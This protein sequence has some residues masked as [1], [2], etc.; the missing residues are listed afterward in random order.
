MG[1]INKN[2]N[3]GEKASGQAFPPLKSVRKGGKPKPPMKKFGPPQ[4]GS[5]YSSPRGENPT[6]RRSWGK[7]PNVPVRAGTSS[8]RGMR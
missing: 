3:P 8:R 5:Q 2:L 1:S 4:G 7:G 6:T